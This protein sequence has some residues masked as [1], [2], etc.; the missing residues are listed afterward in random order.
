[1]EGGR[2]I[3]KTYGN[4]KIFVQTLWCDK[5][6]FWLIAFAYANLMV[7]IAK[8]DRAEDCCVTQLVKQVSNMQHGE[9]ME[10]RLMVETMIINTHA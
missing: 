6:N 1:M 3:A 9:H 8:V 7:S 2:R 5:G 10:P 4:D